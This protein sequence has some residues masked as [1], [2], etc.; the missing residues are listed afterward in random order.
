MAQ[1]VV[2]PQESAVFARHFS[3]RGEVFDSF[4][5]YGYP[6]AP[7]APF[8]FDAL[9]NDV[10]LSAFRGAPSDAVSSCEFHSPEGSNGFT[11]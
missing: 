5:W 10:V 7:Q 2:R 8:D 1:L 6:D 11:V 3:E 4:C 9:Q